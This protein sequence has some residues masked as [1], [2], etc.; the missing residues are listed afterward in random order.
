M[1]EESVRMTT[2]LKSLVKSLQRQVCKRLGVYNYIALIHKLLGIEFGNERLNPVFW[3]KCCSVSL[4]RIKS[5]RGYVSSD[6]R[7]SFIC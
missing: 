3:S 2:I 6:S 7:R 5:L 4:F 1:K